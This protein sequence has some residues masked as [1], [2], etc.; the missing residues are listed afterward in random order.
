MI[1]KSSI[2]LIPVI[3][4][5]I[6]QLLC[7]SLEGIQVV[8]RVVVIH[9]GP[10]KIRYFVLVVSPDAHDR[11]LRQGRSAS[12]G[13]SQGSEANVSQGVVVR[14]DNRL[15]PLLQLQNRLQE[16]RVEDRT[17]GDLAARRLVHDLEAHVI[18]SFKKS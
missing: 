18:C 15:D 10:I 6:N 13:R 5:N 2:K 4:I 9:A 3:K 11:A 16:I 1:L 14:G 12:V 17:I 7:A 8:Y